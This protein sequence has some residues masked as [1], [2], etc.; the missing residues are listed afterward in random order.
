MT[1]SKKFLL[2]ITAVFMGIMLLGSLLLLNFVHPDASG[3]AFWILQPIAG[4][5]VLILSFVTASHYRNLNRASGGDKD[6]GYYFKRIWTTLI[7]MFLMSVVISEAVGLFYNGIVGGTRIRMI[8]SGRFFM[9]GFIA[10]GPLFALYLVLIYNMF[11]Q[12][13][14]RDANR[15]VF[16]AHLKILIVALVFLL[17]L[18]A[19]V[20]DSM[21]HTQ[22]V[23]GFGGINI[24]AVFSANVDVYAVDPI[25]DYVMVN[26]NFNIFLTAFTVLLAL[27]VQMAVAIFAYKRGKQAFLKKRLNP[28]EVETDEKF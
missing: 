12:Q 24:Q 11:S 15:K 14:F 18:P 4:F 22:F 27:A 17:M 25:T 26:N 3:M 7:L 9:Q 16:N 6:F 19:A 21:H 23:A 10:K 1:N 20:H 13:G 5:A 28:A 2:I 8:D